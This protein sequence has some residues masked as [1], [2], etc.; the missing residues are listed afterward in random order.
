MMMAMREPPL[1]GLLGVREHVQQEEQLAIADARQPG[2]E[3][4]G[5]IL[6][7]R[8]DRRLRSRFQSLP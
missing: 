7:L 8:L 5:R 4:A 1:L 2:T 6:V 3:A